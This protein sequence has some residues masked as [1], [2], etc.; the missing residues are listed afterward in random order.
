MRWTCDVDGKRTNNLGKD[1]LKRT[2]D[3]TP[4]DTV[5]SYEATAGHTC[6]MQFIQRTYN[7]RSLWVIKCSIT[8]AKQDIPQTIIIRPLLTAQG[9][10]TAIETAVA[11]SCLDATHRLGGDDFHE[12]FGEYGTVVAV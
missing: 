9:I 7:E 3:G 11:S 5:I 4:K 8:P 2:V 12:I 6:S 10:T 1:F